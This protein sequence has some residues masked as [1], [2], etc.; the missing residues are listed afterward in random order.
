MKV[1]ILG[2]N[3]F[4]G[5]HLAE[6]LHSEGYEVFGIDRFNTNLKYNVEVFDITFEDMSKYLLRVRPDY[7]I[8][9]AGKANVPDSIIHPEEDLQ[10]NTL[11]V[12]RVLWA[13]AQNEMTNVRFIQLSSAG[14]YG[15]PE[16]LPIVE[17]DVCK[18]LSPYALHKKMAEDT[19][20]FFRRVYSLD[21]R[22][23]RIFSVY[24][25]GLRK[26]IFWDFYQKIKKNGEL[27]VWGTGNE[28]RDY[29]YIDDLMDAILISLFDGDDSLCIMNVASGIEVKISE[30][31]YIFADKIGLSKER[32]SFNG[33]VRLGEPLN[34]CADISLIKSK[35]FCA[36]FDM[37]TGIE[38][39]VKWLKDNE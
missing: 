6:R 36:K 21:I 38:Q 33:I 1:L 12:N 14:V 35:G 4:I 23:L 15:N 25:P 20:L 39:Y 26:Q 16:R 34:W 10:E 31:V 11:L 22:I 30:A 28:S 8:N 7:I 24:G 29:I 5:S 18:P 2:I 19:C 37:E 13:L 27:E 3:G 17:D 32:I 9:C